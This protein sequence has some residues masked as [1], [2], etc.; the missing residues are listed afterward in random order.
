M[1]FW[2]SLELELSML[3]LRCPGPLSAAVAKL[4][5]SS[6]VRLSRDCAGVRY[7]DGGVENRTIVASDCAGSLMYQGE[8][9]SEDDEGERE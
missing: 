3:C 1:A 2:R 5:S 9:V 4:P 8:Y 7:L 6:W